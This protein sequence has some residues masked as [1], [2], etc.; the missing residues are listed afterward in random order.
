MFSIYL[1]LALSVGIYSC[2]EFIPKI[3]AELF[4]QNRLDDLF[5]SSP[6][7]VLVS[8]LI[9]ATLLA[10]LFAVICLVPTLNRSFVKGVTAE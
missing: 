9:M 4:E 5:Y 10:P 6:I 7:T 2:I 3:R 8:F 1:I